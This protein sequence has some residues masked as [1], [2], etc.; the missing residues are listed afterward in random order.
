[1]TWHLASSRLMRSARSCIARGYYANS[2]CKFAQYCHKLIAMTWPWIW[3]ARQISMRG[4]LWTTPTDSV[5]FTFSRWYS[6]N[7]RL[8]RQPAQNQTPTRTLQIVSKMMTSHPSGLWTMITHRFTL[9][10]EKLLTSSSIL[11]KPLRRRKHP[12][13]SST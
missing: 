1:M 8:K 2:H 12:T 13:L 7:N 9:D 10:S 3:Q 6:G 4:K 11:G 5:N